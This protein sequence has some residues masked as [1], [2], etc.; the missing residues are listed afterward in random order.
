MCHN[1]LE[2]WRGIG[3]LIA[4]T[5]F[6]LQILISFPS[7]DVSMQRPTTASQWSLD[8]SLL[9]LGQSLSF[10]PYYSNSPFCV[11]KA[12]QGL[13][14]RTVMNNVGCFSGH[15]L[16]QSPAIVLLCP[17]VQV[18]K[19]WHMPWSWEFLIPLGWTPVQLG[20]K[21]VLF[22]YHEECNM[23]RNKIVVTLRVSSSSI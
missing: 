12:K 19:S 4:K 11:S 22:R 15:G 21:A 18:F 10:F 13:L 3:R 17:K 20:S 9:W 7:I 1:Y 6:E 5:F 2:A 16:P 14:Q 8:A 23:G